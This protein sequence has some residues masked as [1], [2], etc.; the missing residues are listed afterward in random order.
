[1]EEEPGA[2]MKKELEE[3][4]KRGAVEQHNTPKAFDLK[5]MK[6]IPN[7]HYKKPKETIA[8]NV[9]HLGQLL[10]VISARGGPTAKNAYTT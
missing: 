5:T 7:P 8:N 2:D 10:N 4:G 3:R 1:M 9:K 6:V